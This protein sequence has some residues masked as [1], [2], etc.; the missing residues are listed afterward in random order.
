MR[1]SVSEMKIGLCYC[2]DDARYVPIFFEKLKSDIIFETAPPCMLVYV[3]VE[4][5]LFP[6]VVRSSPVDHGGLLDSVQ[7]EPVEECRRSV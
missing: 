6:D 5:Y 1:Q 2:S 3:G 7:I 4:C